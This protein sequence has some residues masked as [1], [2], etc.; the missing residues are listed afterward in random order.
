[1]PE[2]NVVKRGRYHATVALSHWPQQAYKN[3]HFWLGMKEKQ[4]AGEK[5]NGR[6][7]KRREQAKLLAVVGQRKGEQRAEKENKDKG[8][9]R[10][11]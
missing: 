11:R 2:G 3:S 9:G 10:E 6:E 4:R 1:M 5:E 7:E 8:E